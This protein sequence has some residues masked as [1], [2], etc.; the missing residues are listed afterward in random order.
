VRSFRLFCKETAAR[1]QSHVYCRPSGYLV[2]VGADIA[3][4]AGTAH[5]GVGLVRGGAAGRTQLSS[6][7]HEGLR[8]DF[9]F[10]DNHQS[11][12]GDAN[13]DHAAV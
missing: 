6:M 13:G 8:S 9:P 4:A 7:K 12:Y 5:G 10:V 3:I 11:D 2:R 1:R